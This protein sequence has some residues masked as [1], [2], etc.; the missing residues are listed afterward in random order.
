MPNNRDSSSN[1][2]LKMLKT[3]AAHHIKSVSDLN[4][5]LYVIPRFKVL[6]KDASLRIDITAGNQ[7]YT[8]ET[9]PITP[10]PPPVIPAPPPVIPAPPPPVV[11]TPVVSYEYFL[12]GTTSWTAPLTSVS[13]ITY[14]II[15]GGGG[16]GGARDG[17]AAGGGGGGMAI[18]GTYP[19]TPGQIYTVIVGRGG[20]GGFGVSGTGGFFPVLPGDTTNNT[21]GRVGGTSSFDLANSGPQALGGGSGYH[22]DY[23]PNG[24]G[25]GGAAA[26]P[27]S[28]AS[29]GGNGGSDINNA[30]GGGG[31]SG[32]GIDGVSNTTLGTG[33]AGTTYTI[34]GRN[35]GNPVTYGFGGAGGKKTSP[36]KINGGVAAANTGN[37]GNGGTALF[38]NGGA[39]GGAGGSG[40]VV[41]QY[42]A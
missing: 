28:T 3:I 24:S 19:I 34:V 21:S 10:A 23:Y 17:G 14:W 12:G 18:T 36:I 16:G 2:R 35:S 25:I 41:I 20:N 27:P 39:A 11:Y 5:G 32:A 13:P 37:G 42:Y 31:S 8:E 29:L 9:P 38:P 33:G 40:L 1:T 4:S 26:T 6:N 22:S 7:F 15:G 30:G